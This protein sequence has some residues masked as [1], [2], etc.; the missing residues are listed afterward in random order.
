MAEKRKRSSHVH[1]FIVPGT[2]QT[3]K[4]EHLFFMP[5]DFCLLVSLLARKRIYC[6]LT[7]I[8]QQ[9]CAKHRVRTRYRSLP[10]IDTIVVIRAIET[11]LISPSIRC[12]YFPFYNRKR[13]NIITELIAAMSNP[14]GS[15][16]RPHIL[17][18]LLSLPFPSQGAA[19]AVSN[20]LAL[21]SI[22]Q[23]QNI[24]HRPFTRVLGGRERALLFVKV[25]MRF[26]ETSNNHVLCQQAKAAVAICVRQ[27]R[28]GNPAYAC[29]RQSLDLHLS[30]LLGRHVF[31]SVQLYCEQQ[32]QRRGLSTLIS[33][34]I[35]T[36]SPVSF[37]SL[38]FSFWYALQL[39]MLNRFCNI[40]LE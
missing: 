23:Q 9:S 4:S 38:F 1:A 34:G 24:S 10:R 28:Q 15:Q 37:I 29:L 25:L 8:N 40:P 35:T 21:P 27:N 16:L 18:Y 12:K 7:Y 31:D 6:N 39:K 32:C 26:L 3:F 30:H 36:W 14:H 20:Q 19:R 13:G 5:S 11:G 17:Q 2:A 33:H 22:A